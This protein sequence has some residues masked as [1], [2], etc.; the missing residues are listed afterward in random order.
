MCVAVADEQHVGFAQRFATVRALGGAVGALG[1]GELTD[2]P[3]AASDP[4]R[5]DV[6][7][8][9]EDCALLT[10]GLEGA[11]TVAAFDVG[12]APGASLGAGG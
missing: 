2:L 9:A 3:A 10:G 11:K 6:L 4:P 8:A 5:H 7:E 1:L 12:P